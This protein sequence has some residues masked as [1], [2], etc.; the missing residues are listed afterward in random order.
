MA[1]F[2]LRIFPDYGPRG[3]RHF[4]ACVVALLGA[5]LLWWLAMSLSIIFLCEPVSYHW[6]EWD[7]E[8]EGKVSRNFH[9]TSIFARTPC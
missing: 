5:T 2:Y 1:F 6:N 8:H 7:G 3:K 4:Y 9:P